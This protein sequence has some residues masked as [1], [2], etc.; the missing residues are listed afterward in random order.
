MNLSKLTILFGNLR[1][2]S[3]QNQC[4]LPAGGDTSRGG[5]PWAVLAYRQAGPHRPQEAKQCDNLKCPF[6]SALP[7]K[8]MGLS[9]QID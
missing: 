6:L 1:I 5:P 7:V 9:L 3:A 2:L 8:L 4:L